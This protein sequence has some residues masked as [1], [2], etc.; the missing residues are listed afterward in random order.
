M[1]VMS[2]AV[3]YGAYFLYIA[4]FR[5]SPDAHRPYA[6]F[7]PALRRALVSTFV[8]SCGKGVRVK[9]NADI[10]PHIE[11]G[12]LSELGRSCQ[13]YGGVKIG[14]EVLMGP[15]VKLITRNHRH[16]DLSRP[17]RVQDETFAPI[18]IGNDVWLGANVV[19][20]PGVDIGDH[21]IIGAGSIVTKSIPPFSIAVGNPARVI[22]DR[23]DQ[24]RHGETR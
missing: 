10:S 24:E 20:L 1:N 21:S 13:I 5:F 12:D 4:I 22:R 15:D 9:F 11:I 7:F 3:R 18:R 17:V 6:L 2:K 19:V 14:S 8:D 23:R 16:D